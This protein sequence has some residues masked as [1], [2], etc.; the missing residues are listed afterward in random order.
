MVVKIPKVVKF[1]LPVVGVILLIFIA[2]IGA[3][4][5]NQVIQQQ[6]QDNCDTEE[7]QTASPVS[8]GKKNKVKGIK[9]KEYTRGAS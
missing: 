5:G 6:Q 3:F 1:A 4:A 8:G 2:I 9:V 7:T